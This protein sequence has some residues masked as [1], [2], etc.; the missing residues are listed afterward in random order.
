MTDSKGSSKPLRCTASDVGVNSKSLVNLNSQV[1]VTVNNFKDPPM[2]EKIMNSES[3]DAMNEK[4]LEQKQEPAD[5]SNTKNAISQEKLPQKIRLR[6]LSETAINNITN[7]KCSSKS[8]N[9]ESDYES[10]SKLEDVSEVPED[11]LLALDEEDNKEMFS[12]SVSEDFEVLE[13]FEFT[14][15][16]FLSKFYR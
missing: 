16:H 6:S 1:S 8:V 2:P 13:N 15:L 12:S 7:W 10:F 11:K 14:G 3:K 5:D 9:S 4:S